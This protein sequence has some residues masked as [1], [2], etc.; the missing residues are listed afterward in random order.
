MKEDK[1]KRSAQEQGREGRNGS[2]FLFTPIPFLLGGRWDGYTIL[3][4]GQ[5]GK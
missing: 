1:A 4:K 2:V 3:Q 5:V